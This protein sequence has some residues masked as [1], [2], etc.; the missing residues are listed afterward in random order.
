MSILEYGHNVV[1]NKGNFL[2]LRFGAVVTPIDIAL[3]KSLWK[4]HDICV[5]GI[6]L[7]NST[8]ICS[9]KLLQVTH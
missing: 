3:L 9:T 6:W 7:L 1:L 4:L 2:F 8:F 5:K